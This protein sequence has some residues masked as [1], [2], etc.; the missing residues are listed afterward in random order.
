PSS[1][2]VAS[3]EQVSIPPSY[4]TPIANWAS[5][6]SSAYTQATVTPAAVSR[7]L[8][9]QSVTAARN[10]LAVTVN[11][12]Q[13]VSSTPVLVLGLQSRLDERG[14]SVDLHRQFGAITSELGK[15]L[16]SILKRLVGLISS[17]GTLLVNSMLVMIIA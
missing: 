1:S 2:P 15:Q 7:P 12:E 3:L 13:I 4:L 14:I 11:A 9:D 16:L 10:L 17:I 5:A 6:L 8:L